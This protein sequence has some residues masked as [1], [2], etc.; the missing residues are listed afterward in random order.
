VPYLLEKLG[1]KLGE[2]FKSVY[3][4]ITSLTQT[5]K[6][7]SNRVGELE[8]SRDSV[9][10]SLQSLESTTTE[11]TNNITTLQTQGDN[12]QE[13]LTSLEENTLSSY[14]I[15]RMVQESKET[16]T[17]CSTQ[18]TQEEEEQSNIAEEATQEPQE[19]TDY[20]EGVSITDR[21]YVP[22]E[23]YTIS[24]TP[25]QREETASLITYEV[26]ATLTH[27]ESSES[28]AFTFDEHSIV[29]DF[30]DGLQILARTTLPDPSVYSITFEPVASKERAL[31]AQSYEV[32]ATVTHL[33]SGVSKPFTFT[34]S[35]PA[36][37]AQYTEDGRFELYL[38]PELT[39]AICTL[40][41]A[42]GYVKP[43]TTD[44]KQN[45]IATAYLEVLGRTF[46]DADGFAYWYDSTNIDK[47]QAEFNKDVALGSL[48]H[49][50]CNIARENAISYLLSIGYKRDT[51][52]VYLETPVKTLVEEPWTERV[53]CTTYCR[54]YGSAN[55]GSWNGLTIWYDCNVV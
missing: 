44:P 4:L 45:K 19:P 10:S 52:S 38:A 26:T 54:V 16:S 28:T 13:R 29:V 33:A 46:I 5:L 22:L 51:N 23:G 55:S 21:Y 20:F 32:T 17:P 2:E 11:N 41:D 3:T 27:I 25:A 47:T 40:S 50:E 39:G 7:N 53:L 8:D 14:E 36:L 42:L 6:A 12:F 31:E 30:F 37:E 35:V 9:N 15:E 1:I 18:E 49:T 48:P 34:E 43:D 24:Y